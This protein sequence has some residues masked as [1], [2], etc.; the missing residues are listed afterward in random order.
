MKLGACSTALMKFGFKD[1]LAHLA[2][3]GVSAIEIVCAGFQTNLAYGDPAE[4][5]QNGEARRA[6]QEAIAEHNLEVSALAIHGQP[7]SPNK[8]TAARYDE[9]FR[10]ACAFAEAIGVDRLVLLAGIPEGAEGDRAPCW[11]TSAF[12]PF[13]RTILDWQ[14]EK[15]VIPYWR[16]HASIAEAHGCRLCFEMHP[17]DVVYN[18]A[19]LMRLRDEIGPVVGANFDPSHLFWQ[20]IDTLEALRWLGPAV[21]YVHAKDTQL[22]P[23]SRVNGVL[24]AKPFDR[25]GERAWTFRTVGFGHG[26]TYWRDFLSTLRVIGYDDV[27]SVEHEDEYLDLEEGLEKGVAFLKPML[28]D[29][30]RGPQ[31]WDYAGVEQEAAL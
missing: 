16:E 28:L 19:S 15:R 4:L 1:G 9:E 29:A 14:W 27:V 2:S 31:W 22:Q 3:L 25:I 24:D 30:P 20:G 12:P 5:L 13:N 18:P 17:C 10:T 7:L 11:V 21:Y 23:A 8:T 6:W 26:A